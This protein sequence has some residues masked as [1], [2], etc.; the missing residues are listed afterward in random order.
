MRD[1]DLTDEQWQLIQPL[2]PP[3]KKRG[4]PRVDDRQV[5]NGI[6]Y[7]LR[8]GIPWNDLP[9]RY[10]GDSTCHWHLATW[11]ADGTWE[12]IW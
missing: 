7:V 10:S 4:R 5:L 8:T 1:C 9:Q 12:R 3:R 6:L 11:E 2:L